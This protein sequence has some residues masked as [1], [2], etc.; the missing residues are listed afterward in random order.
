MTCLRPGPRLAC[1]LLPLLALMA[2]PAFARSDEVSFTPLDDAQYDVSRE[3]V[4]QLLCWHDDPTQLHLSRAVVLAYHPVGAEFDL[5]LATRHGVYGSQGLRNCRVRG[6]PLEIGEIV[7]V[8]TGHPGTT[9]TSQFSQDWAI[10]TTRGRLPA[11]VPRLRVLVSDSQPDGQL[12]FLRRPVDQQACSLPQAPDYLTEPSLI[13]HDC[14]R[15][16]GLS[17]TPLV[18]Q[19]GDEPYIVAL[20]VGQY[21]ILDG[22]RQEYG[23][24]RRVSDDFLDALNTVLVRA[25]IARR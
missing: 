3:S 12:T 24:A 5:L 19:I 20:H 23:V 22:E 21:L 9:D 14:D 1:L 13:F 18:T 11:S 4:V 17:G 6:V 7:A 16:P 2:A 10:L 8:E 15:R 25:D